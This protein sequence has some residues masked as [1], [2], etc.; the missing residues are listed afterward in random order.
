MEVNGSPRKN[1]DKHARACV[2]VCLDSVHLTENG[3]FPFFNPRC[4]E[5]NHLPQLF[6]GFDNPDICYKNSQIQWMF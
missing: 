2:C 1:I 3:L 6:T 4:I 5:I